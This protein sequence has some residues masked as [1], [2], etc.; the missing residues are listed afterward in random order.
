MHYDI[1]QRFAAR[2]CIVVVVATNESNM[3]S[4]FPKE[5]NLNGSD[6]TMCSDVAGPLSSGSGDCFELSYRS[7]K[8]NTESLFKATEY[9]PPS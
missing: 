5:G 7:N 2:T 3:A 9:W 4:Y 1:E 8:A 6:A